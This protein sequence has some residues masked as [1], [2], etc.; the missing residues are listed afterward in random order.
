M[1]GFSDKYYG[2]YFNKKKNPYGSW[3]MAAIPH[4]SGGTQINPYGARGSFAPDWGSYRKPAWERR[5]AL[6]APAEKPA[7]TSEEIQQ[8]IARYV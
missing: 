5:E 7:F 1:T 8:M 3:G 6:P 2:R 4:N